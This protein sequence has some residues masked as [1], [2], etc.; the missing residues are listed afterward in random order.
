[1][2]SAGLLPQVQATVQFGSAG[3]GQRRYG[4]LAQGQS[5]VLGNAGHVRC[6]IRFR[7]WI[8]GDL[9]EPLGNYRARCGGKGRGKEGR[10]RVGDLAAHVFPG[11][12]RDVLAQS[13]LRDHLEN[14]RIDDPKA[15]NLNQRAVK[16]VVVV[17]DLEIVRAAKL[18]LAVKRAQLGLVDERCPV[19]IRP[20]NPEMLPAVGH[21]V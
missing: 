20:L 5:P 13:I 3:V 15:A 10:V 19:G 12:Q 17:D 11:V 8:D 4:H 16:D 14:G 7:N 18:R 1:V 9:Q 2:D 21:H 6:A